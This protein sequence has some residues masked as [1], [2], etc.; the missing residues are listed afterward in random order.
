MVLFLAD[1][2]VCS[3]AAPAHPAGDVTGNSAGPARRELGGLRNVRSDI[4]FMNKS[5]KR[6]GQTPPSRS[7]QPPLR[8]PLAWVHGEVKTPPFSPEARV[9]AGVLLSKLQRGEKLSLPHSRPMPSIG[10]RCHELRIPDEKVT[11][12][13]IYRI[14]PDAIPIWAVFEKKTEATPQRVI[15]TCKERIKRYDGH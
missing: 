14:D 8:K 10:A 9:E 5:K 12:R 6:T 2:I 1:A 3:P 13:I 7:P 11:W 4:H 15:D